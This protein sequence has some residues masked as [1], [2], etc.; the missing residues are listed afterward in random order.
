MPQTFLLF[1]QGRS[2]ACVNIS[3]VRKERVYLPL[4]FVRVVLPQLHVDGV[5]HLDARLRGNWGWA[6]QCWIILH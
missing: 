1:F 2:L 3:D 4:L 5:N 6:R